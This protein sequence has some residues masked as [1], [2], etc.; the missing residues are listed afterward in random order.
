MAKETSVSSFNVCRAWFLALIFVASS[1]AA[2]ATNPL[3]SAKVPSAAPSRT[4]PA[5][6]FDLRDGAVG[7]I[8]PSIPQGTRAPLLVL[9]HGA[10]REGAEMVERFRTEADRHGIILLAPKSAGATWDTVLQYNPDYGSF[11]P[12]AKLPPNNPP[13]SF[14]ADVGRVDRAVSLLFQHAAIDPKRIGLLG[15]SD[16]A[17]YALALGLRN[18]QLFDTVI[19]LSPGFAYPTMRKAPQRVFLAHGIKDRI[20]PF[21]NSKREIVPNLQRHGY[22][23]DF[24]RFEGGHELP[25]DVVAQAMSFFLR[26][27]DAAD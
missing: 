19:A 12:L 16:G 23:V 11:A 18:P 24:V 4:A 7:Y 21:I 20:L 27:S 6:F 13:M 10:G 26:S 5:G 1:L 14:G 22:K 2:A 15:F 9:L 3:L 25:D 8:P 17:T